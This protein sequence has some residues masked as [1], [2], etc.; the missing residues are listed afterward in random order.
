MANLSVPALPAGSN[1]FP[2]HVLD[3]LRA[4][5]AGLDPAAQA[6]GCRLR[7]RECLRAAHYACQDGDKPQALTW[8]KAAH[9]ARMAAVVWAERARVAS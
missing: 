1:T 2:A 6:R 3:A 7:A 9:M 4:A 8:L 5:P